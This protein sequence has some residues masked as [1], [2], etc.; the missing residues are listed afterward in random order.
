MSERVSVS[1]WM[2]AAVP[3]MFETTWHLGISPEPG[4]I[5]YFERAHPEVM[6]AVRDRLTRWLEPE[7]PAGLAPEPLREVLAEALAQP[8][9]VAVEP[10][11]GG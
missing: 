7:R 8:D 5:I 10:Q 1:V 9:P 6:R 4:L 11:S 3:N 2:G